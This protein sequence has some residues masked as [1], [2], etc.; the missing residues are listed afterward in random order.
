ML[1]ARHGNKVVRIPDE[2]KSDYISLG[3][4]ITDMEGKVIYDPINNSEDVKALKEHITQKDAQ[5]AKLQ[6]EIKLLKE[7]NEEAAAYAEKADKEI[8]ELKASAKKEA[9]DTAKK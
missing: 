7:K 9:K 1:K 4:K 8:A 5:I 3:Y 6:A 2:K